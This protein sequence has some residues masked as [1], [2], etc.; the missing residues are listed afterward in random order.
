MGCPIAQN[1]IKIDVDSSSHNCAELQWP[2]KVKPMDKGTFES[3]LRFSILPIILMATVGP[4]SGG[5][6]HGQ[7]NARPAQPIG[8]S[9]GS[10]PYSAAFGQ[11]RYTPYP[12]KDPTAAERAVIAGRAYR[13]ILDAW[14]K[15]ASATPGQQ[16]RPAHE[17]I[18]LD[19]ELVERLAQW[20][21]R[22]QEAEDNAAKSLAGRY[23]SLA[24]HLSRMSALEDGRVRRDGIKPSEIG[25]GRPVESQ[26]SGLCAEIARF[27]R[28]LDEGGV[29]RVAPEIINFERPLNPVGVAVTPADRVEIAGRA[30]RAIVS[31]AVDRFLAPPHSADARR[32]DAAIVDAS[33]AERLGNW[34]DLWRQ[35]QD[36]GA[37]DP[38]SR[39]AVA[40]SGS[41]RLALAGTRLAGP[42]VLPANIKSHLERM[43]AIETGR[44]LNDALG[45]GNRRAGEPLDMTRMR[46]FVAVARHFRLEAESQLADVSRSTSTDA[47][48][49]GRA[50]AASQH[51]QAIL[52]EAV[53]RYLAMP[54]AHAAT[55]DSGFIFDARLAERLGSWS[56]RWGRAQARTGEAHD[57]RFAA[58]R[59]HFERMAA[60]EDGRAL[61]EALARAGPRIGEADAL[62]PPREFAEVARFFRLEARW[63]LELVRSR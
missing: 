63:E 34:S 56:I 4:V 11:G 51:Y 45:P 36:D 23:Q 14:V 9:K 7:G 15:R 39:S 3:I 58:V 25:T 10:N 21:L 22:W 35:A 53:R 54:R 57:A 41:T 26:P 47:T 16:G 40:R 61:H 12:V 13:T 37:T 31:A 27:Y 55:A 33:L 8:N 43:N 30:Y 52:D 1:L 49:A 44:C 32:D 62:P 6:Q 46:D 17:N 28:P 29:D 18:L 2:S 24:S 5:R 42:A 38:S 50:A 60:L 59:S 48:A 19:S 20:S